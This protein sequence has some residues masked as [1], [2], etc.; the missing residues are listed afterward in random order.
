[1]TAS[2]LA[3]YIGLLAEARKVSPDPAAFLRQIEAGLRYHSTEGLIHVFRTGS[4]LESGVA[5]DLLRRCL[6]EPV[7]AVD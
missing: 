4:L 2:P 1:V 6:S 7:N 5:G 3:R